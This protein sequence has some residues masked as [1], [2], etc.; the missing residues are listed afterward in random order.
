MTDQEV[1]QVSKNKTA[2]VAPYMSTNKKDVTDTSD[3]I[4]TVVSV[5]I[6][7]VVA[8]VIVA[9]FFEEDYQSLMAGLNPEVNT[10]EK[11]ITVKTPDNTIGSNT[12][13]FVAN[14]ST[15]ATTPSTSQP[16]LITVY[17]PYLRPYPQVYAPIPPQVPYGMPSKQAKAYTN[18][19]LKRQKA[20]AEMMEMRNAAILRM[21]KNRVDRRQQMEQQRAQAQKAYADMLKR[22]Q[23]ASR[24]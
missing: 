24:I 17:N 16:G 10:G 15:A 23:D 1:N 18:M 5:I 11:V 14:T 20:M 7:L 8:I 3:K 21:E 4:S 9:S 13:T 12:E 2:E 19:M 6:I 22:R